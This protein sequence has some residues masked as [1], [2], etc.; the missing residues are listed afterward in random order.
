MSWKEKEF[1][2]KMQP[3][4]ND[5]Y[6]K[7]FKNIIEIKRSTREINDE[8]LL[9]MDKELA[10]DTHLLFQ[11]G[12]VLTLQEKTLRESK[13]RFQSFTFEYYNDPNTKDEGEWFKLAAQ[14]YFFGYANKSENNYNQYMIL[15]VPK[16]RLHL[17][18]K[19]GIELLENK[20]LRH[21]RPPAK[22]NFFAIPFWLIKKIQVDNDII[23]LHR[24]N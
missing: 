2:E 6:K 13:Q 23:I 1:E 19:V 10:I 7:T 14:L 20:Y 5:I 3:V 22:A 16:L 15:D 18:N 12:T 24:N 21:N 17:K 11:D 9:F 4:I 8:K